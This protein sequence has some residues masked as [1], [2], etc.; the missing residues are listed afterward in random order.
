MADETDFEPEAKEEEDE[1]AADEAVEELE[2]AED[3]AVD[4]PEAKIRLMMQLKR[5]MRL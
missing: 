4:E 5:N 2:T 1:T 3:E